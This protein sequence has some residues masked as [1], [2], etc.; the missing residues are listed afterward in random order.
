LL[1]EERM[2]RGM[3]EATFV[4]RVKYS[5]TTVDVMDWLGNK[6]VLETSNQRSL[7]ST[8]VTLN[9]EQEKIVKF[10]AILPR[11]LNPATRRA[12]CEIIG[13]AQAILTDDMVRRIARV[14][15]HDNSNPTAGGGLKGTAG[16]KR[17][18]DS[19]RSESQRGWMN[20]D[21]PRYHF[22]PR[23]FLHIAHE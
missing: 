8:S 15:P 16:Q 18:R 17:D 14:Q 19:V 11:F 21:R 5:P 23:Q 7:F 6:Y 3:A 1:E 4:F 9:E 20:T 10:I 22:G 12:T 13:N 2:Q